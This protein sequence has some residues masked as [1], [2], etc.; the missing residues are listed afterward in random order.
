MIERIDIIR[1]FI[2]LGFHYHSLIF[3]LLPIFFKAI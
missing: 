2:V 1:I 3:Y